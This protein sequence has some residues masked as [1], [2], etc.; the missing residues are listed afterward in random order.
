MDNLAIIV[1]TNYKYRDLWPM[2]FGE[3]EINF[4]HKNIYTFVDNKDN[5]TGAPDDFYNGI[6]EYVKLIKYNYFD[7]FRDQYLGCLRQVPE[8]Y[9]IT[10]NDDY[11]LYKPVDIDKIKEYIN[12]L[13]TTDYSFVRFTSAADNHIEPFQKGLYKIPFYNPNLYSQTASLWKTRTLEKIHVN[14]PAL[15]I[16]TRGEKDGHFEEHACKVC[17]NMG[18]EGLSCWNG[19]PKR[20]MSHYDNDV[21]PYIASALVKGKWNLSEYSNELQPLIKK[22]NIDTSVRGI[23]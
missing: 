19:E 10:M 8:K 5:H 3:L 16:G 17:M 4:P 9:V 7:S 18:I 14:G 22:Y 21:F 6:P 23:Y 1:N 13:E 11:I 20:G 15:H 12:I 2:Y